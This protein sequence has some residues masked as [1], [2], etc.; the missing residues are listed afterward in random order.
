[1]GHRKARQA[2]Q[3]ASSRSGFVV[4]ADEISAHNFSCS[5]GLKASNSSGVAPSVKAS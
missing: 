3:G 1:V 2:R 4:E 5:P